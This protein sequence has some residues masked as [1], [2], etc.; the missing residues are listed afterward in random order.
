MQ[1]AN[2]DWR[3]EWESAQLPKK[4]V[5]AIL[6][7]GFVTK[8]AFTMAFKDDDS[9]ESFIERLLNKKKFLGDL[10]DDWACHPVAG[11]LRGLWRAPDVAVPKP[12]NENAVGLQ[13][14]TP[15]PALLGI[16][17]TKLE[18]AQIQ[19]LW[20]R[21]EKDFPSESLDEHSRPCRQNVHN[22][23]KEGDLRFTPWKFI[24][25]EAEWDGSKKTCEKKEKSTFLTFQRDIHEGYV[26]PSPFGAQWILSL[27]GICWALVGW[28]HLAQLMLSC[29]SLWPMWLY[30]LNMCLKS[31]VC[32]RPLAEAEAADMELCRRLG[33]EL[34]QGWSLAEF[35]V[36]VA[37]AYACP[38]FELC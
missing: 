22:Q 24:L 26:S 3:N 38:L 30:I 1:F 9:F 14:V 15:L 28:R 36:A 25:S 21:F 11:M 35:L 8:V 20:K 6:E 5:S 13:D 23:K 7:Q 37:T 19:E 27:R 10:D 4:V 2:S 31:L 12:N 34:E 16:T 17:G 33:E 29:G 18:V 32:D